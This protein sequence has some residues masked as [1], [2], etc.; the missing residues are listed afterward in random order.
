MILREY[1]GR[2]GDMIMIG[3]FNT[4][5]QDLD[6]S[7]KRTFYCLDMFAQL[8]ERMVEAWRRLHPE[9]REYSWYSRGHKTG[10]EIGWRIDHAFLLP[11]LV[12]RLV[13]CEYNHRFRAPGLTDHSGMLL[14]L[15]SVDS[16]TH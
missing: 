5:R 9:A 12:P 14:E 10:I 11:S 7:E 1:A 16:S 15:Q 2:P 3:D 13:A 8:E 6:I 4:G